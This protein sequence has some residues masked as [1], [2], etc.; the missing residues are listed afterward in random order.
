MLKNAE[1]YKRPGNVKTLVVPKTNSV[2]F[3]CLGKGPQVVDSALQRVTLLIMKGM[4]PTLQL[5]DLIG[6]G[7][8]DSI[9]L[10]LEQMSDTIRLLAAAVNYISQARKDV[11]RNDLHG[12]VARLCTWETPV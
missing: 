4:I 11:I 1:K 10:H 7:S 8:Q 2:V 5:I 6:Q 3:S 12:S 9:Q